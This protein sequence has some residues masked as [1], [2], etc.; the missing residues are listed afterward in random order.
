MCP[1]KVITRLQQQEER[2]GEREAVER[3]HVIAMAGRLTGEPS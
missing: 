3:G 2:D 1:A